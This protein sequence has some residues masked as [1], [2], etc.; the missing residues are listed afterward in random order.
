VD[1]T[2]LCHFL[3]S[4]MRRAGQGRQIT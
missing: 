3:T 4:T 1:K 2:R